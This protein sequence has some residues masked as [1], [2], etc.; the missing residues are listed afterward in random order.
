MRHNPTNSSPRQKATSPGIRHFVTTRSRRLHLASDI[1]SLP[2]LP[3]NLSQMTGNIPQHIPVDI[4][5]S[6]G[7]KK[8][9]PKI[10][11]KR[12]S[13]DFVY[14]DYM[15]YL[16]FENQICRDYVTEKFF[17]PLSSSAI[18]VVFCGA[19]YSSIGPPNSYIDALAFTGPKE[20][21]EYLWTVAT[22]RTL[23]NRQ[24]KL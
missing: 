21:A 5:G 4:Y 20:L 17:R 7:R 2:E 12:N 10:G 18:P 22:N 24:V 14:R 3:G 6:C 16:A 9:G 13:C 23:Y 11:P 1:S 19:N 8:C 15:F